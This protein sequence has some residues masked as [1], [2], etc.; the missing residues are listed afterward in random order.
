MV[1]IDERG[2]IDTCEG[3]MSRDVIDTSEGSMSRDVIEISEGSIPKDVQDVNNESI[4][5]QE[6]I[7]VDHN[8]VV[9]YA[10][11]LGVTVPEKVII[12]NPKKS[13]NKGSKKRKSRAEQGKVKKART[14][15]KVT[16]K[17]CACNNCDR[18]V[19]NKRVCDQEDSDDD[20]SD[21]KYEVDGED[22]VNE[23]GEEDES[24]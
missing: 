18:L 23:V 5:G 6:Q 13:S 17:Q 16:F 22:E 14:T 9:I 11:L 10:N 8:K 15:R 4:E 24:D 19:H 3:S 7:D 12:K 1:G 2:I 21:A 20:E